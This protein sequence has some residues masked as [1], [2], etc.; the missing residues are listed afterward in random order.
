LLIEV[1]EAIVFVTQQAGIDV[2]EQEIL[3]I[4]SWFDSMQ[5]DKSAHQQARAD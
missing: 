3:F 4:K 2:E 5:I 1:S